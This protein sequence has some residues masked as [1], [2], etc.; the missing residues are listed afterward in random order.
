MTA[1]PFKISMV[2]ALGSPTGAKKIFPLTASDVNAEFGLFP[3]GSSEVV[4]SG[5]ADV[6]I[7]D[8]I[9]SAAG[10]D[11]SQLEFYINGMAEGTKLL[12]A[13][14]IATTVVRPFQSAPLR[15]PKG[16]TIKIK[17]LT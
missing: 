6:Y 4:L 13:T 1:A 2:G 7:V 8:M 14:S 17:Q 3:S 9:L 12:N 15:I 5:S 16:A 10:T 11:T